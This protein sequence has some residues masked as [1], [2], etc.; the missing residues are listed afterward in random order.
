[1]TYRLLAL[2]ID[3]TL[4]KSNHRLAKETKEAIEYAKD[5]GVYVTLATGRAFPSAKKIANALKLD[6]A[7]LV[8]HDGAYIASELEE[9]IYERR[10]DS[11]RAYQIVDILENYHCHVRLLHEKYSIANKVRQRNYLIAKMNIG[12]REPLFYPV[13]FVDSV[14]HH[15]ID[16]PLTVPKIR[17][18]FWNEKERRDAI[19]EI[20]ESV[21]H[22]NLTSSAEGSLDIV[23]ASASKARGMQVL[24]KKLGI[25][26]QEMVAVGSFDNDIEMLTQSGL[27]IAMGTSP[28]HVKEAADWVTRSNNQN[29]VGYAVR[30]VFRKQLHPAVY[31]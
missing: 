17:A 31:K 18:H 19:E 11:D 10:L 13:N 4:L 22:V 28:K 24:G 25:K 9:P 20:N 21:R 3:G 23:D 12:V 6:D 16:Q 7:Y 26:L 2:D 30:E 1:M 15:L 5:K 14:S 29:G 8:T 27:G